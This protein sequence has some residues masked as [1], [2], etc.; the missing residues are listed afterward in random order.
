MQ[1]ALNYYSQWL[2]NSVGVYPDDVW[3]DVWS[4]NGRQVFRHHHNMGYT[5]PRFLQMIKTNANDVLLKPEF[6][7]VRHSGAIGKDIK[8]V[9]PIIQYP[10]DQVELRFN[11]GTRGNGVDQPRWP[12]DLMTEVVA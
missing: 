7:K 9:K 10:G 2:V 8:G 5:L 6:F 1:V 12:E 3:Q 11:V 4:R